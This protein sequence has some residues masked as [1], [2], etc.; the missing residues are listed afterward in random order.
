MGALFDTKKEM[1]QMKQQNAP[2][3]LRRVR[4]LDSIRL[5]ADDRTY[6]TE[7][8]YL[9]DHPV[10][11][12]VGIFEYRNPDGTVRRELRLPEHVFAEKSLK[13]Y[14]GKPVIITHS[15]GKISKNNVDRE[16]IGTI[17]SNGYQDGDN[18][19]AEI[20]IHNTDAMKSSGLKELSLGYNL[21]LIEEP[22]EWNGQ[23]YDAVQTNIV[24]N[25]LALVASARAGDQA[26][27]NMDG[28][29]EPELKGGKVTASGSG[30]ENQEHLPSG[31]SAGVDD[32]K[33]KGGKKTMANLNIDGFD[34]TPEQ[35]VEAISQFKASHEAGGA[36]AAA[37]DGAGVPGTAGKEP[38]VGAAKQEPAAGEVPPAVPAAS[39]AQEPPAA[40]PEKK[41]ADDLT[42]LISA[43]EQLLAALKAKSGN[44]DGAGT[45]ATGEGAPA[46]AKQDGEES[47]EPAGCGKEDANVDGS[48][49]MSRSLNADSADDLFRQRLGIC[50]VGDRLG[51]EGLEAMS[52][53]DGKKAVIAK[54]LPDMRLDGKDTAYVDAAYDIAV[55]KACS[56]KDVDYQRQ[57]MAVGTP[58]GMRTDGVGGDGS[59]A[60][61]ARQ[62]MIEREG[63]SE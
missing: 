9:V 55:E 52:I 57:Q 21:D 14:R 56:R 61:R 37:G 34:M 24:I 4:R 50:R 43:V 63:G 1:I 39:A 38:P 15:A 8:G 41:D 7:E 11:T 10:L 47:G 2:P 5:D 31:S 20:I 46:A 13:T 40:E 29:D 32:K 23:P 54:V 28:S 58:P 53:P 62:K 30:R 22:G 6:F 26:R 12:S 45:A 60:S 44:M 16:Q 19:R 33:N 35:L 49:D 18:V 59:M 25:H 17:L 36:A 27:L 48:G 3:V 42:P 51:L